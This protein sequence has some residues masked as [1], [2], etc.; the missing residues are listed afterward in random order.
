MTDFADLRRSAEALLAGDHADRRSTAQLLYQLI[1]KLHE[2]E[3]AQTD[4]RNFERNMGL[5]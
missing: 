4:R 3:K 2:D 5:R 1:V